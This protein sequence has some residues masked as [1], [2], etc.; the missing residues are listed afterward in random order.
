MKFLLVDIRR[1]AL[2]DEEAPTRPGGALCAWEEIRATENKERKAALVGLG[3]GLGPAV[4]TSESPGEP[5]VL[6]TAKNLYFK[7]HR[8][9][10]L[11]NIDPVVFPLWNVSHNVLEFKACLETTNVCLLWLSVIVL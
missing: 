9:I 10:L 6:L 5:S 3:T 8:N 1:S 4:D 7:Q 2:S 11:S